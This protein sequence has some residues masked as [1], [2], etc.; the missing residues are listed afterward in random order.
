[1]VGAAIFTGITFIPILA[2]ENLGTDVI[3]ITLLV[4]SYS[5]AA[6]ISSYIFGRA[7]DMYSRRIVLRLGLFLSSF[8]FGLIALSTTPEIL[9]IVGTMSGFSIVGGMTRRRLL[10][11]SAVN[12]IRPIRHI[13]G[14]IS[15][16][17]NLLRASPLFWL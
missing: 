13:A 2:R 16:V 5:T 11:P 7:G 9:F 17:K 10:K 3:F 8:T 1:M 12:G 6:F 14:S 4:G 15:K